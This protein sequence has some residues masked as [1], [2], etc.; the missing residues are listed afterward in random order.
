MPSSGD[1]ESYF[2]ERNMNETAAAT[3]TSYGKD[4]LDSSFSNRTSVMAQ[5]QTP[6]Y[7]VRRKD[8]APDSPKYSLVDLKGPQDNNNWIN[9]RDVTLT[10]TENAIL[11]KFDIIP[12]GEALRPGRGEKALEEETRFVREV[13]SYGQK[14]DSRFE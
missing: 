14:W 10:E 8:D 11:D 9:V 6:E 12:G 2:K 7:V 1:I 13:F 3:L 4:S 5:F